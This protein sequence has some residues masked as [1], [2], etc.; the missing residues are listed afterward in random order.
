MRG[1]SSKTKGYT[2]GSPMMKALVALFAVVL[3]G[4]VVFQTFLLSEISREHKAQQQ[5]LVCFN[6]S[7]TPTMGTDWIECR[8]VAIR[9]L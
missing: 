7:G 4:T 1:A 8:T 3:V 6:S 5:A 9:E 2:K